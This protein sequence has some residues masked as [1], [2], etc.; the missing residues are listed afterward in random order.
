MS[1]TPSV[2]TS[3]SAVAPNPALAAPKP[4]TAIQT[5]EQELIGFIKQREQAVANV[6]AV[7]GAIQAAQHLLARLK[8][9]EAEAVKLGKEVVAKVE[10]EVPVVEAAVEAE[11]KKV[12][13]FVKTEASKL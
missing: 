9:A 4:L 7:E 11:A 1:T 12:I 6:H 3:V 10:A 13:E 2:P 5:I 8:A